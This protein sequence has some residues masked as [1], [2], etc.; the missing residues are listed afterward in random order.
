MVKTPTSITGGMGWIPGWG[1]KI[2]HAAWCSKKVK[3]K[4]NY[5]Q[6]H[7]C[8]I[9]TQWNFIKPLKKKIQGNPAIFNN[10]NRP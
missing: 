6:I 4:I 7:K 3:E 10:M 8:G 9:H 5:C 1:A 2:L